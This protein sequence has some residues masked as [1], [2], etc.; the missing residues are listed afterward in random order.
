MGDSNISVGPILTPCIWIETKKSVE[1]FIQGQ[2]IG[3][4]LLLDN[5]HVLNSMVVLMDCN[6][7]W[8]ICFFLKMENLN[9]EQCLIKYTISDPGMTLAMIFHSSCKAS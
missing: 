6:D 7:H 3:E 9:D 4:L 8:L 2:A 5:C 1:D